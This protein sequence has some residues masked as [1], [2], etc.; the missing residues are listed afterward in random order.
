VKAVAN[1]DGGVMVD[2]SAPHTNGGTIAS[3]SLDGR[4]SIPG[5]QVRVGNIASTNVVVPAS[6]LTMGATYT[7]TI[8]AILT[9]G[10]ASQPSAPS[11]AVTTQAKPGA[12]RTV[13]AEGAGV[14]AL[15]VSWRTAVANGSPITGYTVSSSSGQRVDTDASATSATL[16][17][18]PQGNRVTITVTA[19]SAVGDTAS[20]PVTAIV[21]AFTAVGTVTCI[22]PTGSTF[23]DSGVKAYDAPDGTVQGSFPNGAQVTAVC[24][25]EGSAVYANQYNTENG[26]YSYGK[27]SGWWLR[28]P[29]GRFIPYA[30]VNFPGP[31]NQVWN[32]L[33]PCYNLAS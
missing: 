22:N 23:C 6:L 28:L 19:H 2:W 30:W 17:G 4:T 14:G 16:T 32:E 11:N 15:T 8:T 7:F 21:P 9:S 31:E 13:T 1:P 33:Q 20:E 18:L 25:S 26:R 24:R 29:D 5:G 12:P 3:Y 27:H 10:A